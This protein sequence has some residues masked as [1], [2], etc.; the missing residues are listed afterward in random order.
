[1]N[2]YK[3]Y[4]HTTPSGWVYIGQTCRPVE[5][6][7]KQGYS[8]N[9]HFNRAIQKY[10]WDSIKHEILFEGLTK[11]EADQIEI[12]LITEQRIRGKCLNIA[13]G[14]DGG[15]T[16]SNRSKESQEITRRK[17]S[18]HAKQQVWTNERCMRISRSKIGH[19]VSRD[20]RDKISKSLIGQNN[21]NFGKPKT[22][23]IRK[24]LSESNKGKHIGPLNKQY[25]LKGPNS[26]MYGRVWVSNGTKSRLIRQDEIDSYLNKGWWRGRK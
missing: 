25:G 19:T 10:G 3:I 11:K 8:C 21:P 1:M 6:R 16:F 18:I 4:R 24:K 22:P 7:W 23:E 2:S 17:N 26:W 15:D 12:E 5:E 13:N 14:G 20:T 9:P